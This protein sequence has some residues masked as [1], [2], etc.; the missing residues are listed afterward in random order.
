MGLGGSGGLD[1]LSGGSEVSVLN[2]L[3]YNC[4]GQTGAMY[5]NRQIALSIANSEVPGNSAAMVRR[6]LS[7]TYLR[8]APPAL[9]PLIV[10]CSPV[11]RCPGGFLLVQG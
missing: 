3:R 11:P 4:M 2:Q 8:I 10:K 7:T 1:G 9:Q 6:Y 5:L